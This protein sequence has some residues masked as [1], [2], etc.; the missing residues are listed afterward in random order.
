MAFYPLDLDWSYL[1]TMGYHRIPGRLRWYDVT[2]LF[3]C[4]IPAEQP[5]SL[6]QHHS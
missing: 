6:P 3:L 2:R 1:L 5:S 4:S